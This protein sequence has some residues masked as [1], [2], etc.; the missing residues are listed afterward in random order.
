MRLDAATI[1][2]IPESL[3]RRVAQERLVGMS[4]PGIVLRQAFSESVLRHL[5]GV[6]FRKS[7]NFEAAVAYRA[8]SPDEFEEINARQ[9]WANWRTIPRNLSG[10]IPDRPLRVLDLCCGIGHS[11]EVLACYLPLD[12]TILGLEF[13][14]QFVKMARERAARYVHLSGRPVQVG[15]TVQSVLETF[16][17]EDG[18]EIPAGSVDLANCCGAIGVH[19]KPDK[20][21]IVAQEIGRV[22]KPG[23]LA[24]IDSG[25]TGTSADELVRIF[26]LLRF[27]SLSAARSCIADRG[28]QI[29]FRKVG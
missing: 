16:R 24:T 11:T 7:E 15:F 26:E 14:P 6:N 4:L 10:S 5:R 28:L 17:D 9:R 29:C 2:F 22:L 21:R 23:G 27:Q 19:F 18:C 1:A 8:M 12:S 13:N 3:I 20:S 25:P